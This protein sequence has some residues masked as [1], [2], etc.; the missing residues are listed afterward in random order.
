MRQSISYPFLMVTRDAKFYL[1]DT[2]TEVELK[3]NHGMNINGPIVYIKNGPKP[4][5]LNAARI[6]YETYIAEKPIPQNY[7]VTF[8]DFDENNLSLDNLKIQNKN[9]LSR[10]YKVKKPKI[11][12]ETFD[13]WL[14]PDSIYF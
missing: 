1:K 9:R 2:M 14:G 12:G 5:C 4:I 3:F 8:L 7:S 6:L 11:S 13:T 10:K